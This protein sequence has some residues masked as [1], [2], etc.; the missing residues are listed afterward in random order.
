MF[1]NIPDVYKLHVSHTFPE[2]STYINPKH[3]IPLPIIAA[4]EGVWRIGNKFT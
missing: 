3:A 2:A 1:S 4:G